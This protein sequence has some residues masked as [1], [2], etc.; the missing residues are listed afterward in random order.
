MQTLHP[1]DPGQN[2]IHLNTVFSDSLMAIR[3]QIYN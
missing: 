1:H 3:L 2:S